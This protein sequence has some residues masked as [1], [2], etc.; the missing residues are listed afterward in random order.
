MTNLPHGP[1]LRSGARWVRM[2][3]LWGLA[4]CPPLVEP[5]TPPRGDPEVR[6]YR[7]G[8]NLNLRWEPSSTSSSLGTSGLRGE[9]EQVAGSRKTR[10]SAVC[11]FAGAIFRC[12]V[13][14]PQHPENRALCLTDYITC[15]ELIRK[16]TGVRGG[17][18]DL[19]NPRNLRMTVR[20]WC[21]SRLLWYQ[22][23]LRNGDGSSEPIPV[24]P[25]TVQPGRVAGSITTKHH[26]A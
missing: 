10:D 25:I 20:F 8:L 11:R 26:L 5:N 2:L 17:D 16:R 7:G 21:S 6:G 22:S 1:D 24:Q 19:H 15:T 9:L 23:R 4:A 14:S 18:D 12:A 3:G 13:P